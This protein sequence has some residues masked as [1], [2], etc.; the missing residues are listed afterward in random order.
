[1]DNHEERQYLDL[2]N[3]VISDG[4]HKGDRTGT[5]TLSSFGA[6]MRF[7][8]RD[9]RF[10]LLTTKR[11]FWRGVAEELLWIISGSTDSKKLADKGVHIWD[12]NGSREFLDEMGFKDRRE[13]DL[14]QIYGFQLRHFGATYKDCDTD[15]TGQGVDQLAQVID[16]IKN[17]P[18]DRRI[19]MSAWNPLALHDMALPPCFVAGTKVLTDKG[20]VAIEE[21]PDDA[22]L[23][24]HLGNWKPIN[25]KHVTTKM[26]SLIDINVQCHPQTLSATGE[27]PFYARLAD[28]PAEWI[29][30][31]DLTDKHFVA[32]PVNSRSIMPPTFK[33]AH[34]QMSPPIY[35]YKTL[36]T[37]DEFW[38]MGYFLGDGRVILNNEGRTKYGV[39]FVVCHRDEEEVARRLKA[40]MPTIYRQANSGQWELRDK[41][42]WNILRE[43]GHKAGGKR[44][45]EWVQD[46]PI[47]MV[48]AFVDGY[49]RADGCEMLMTTIS[50]DVAFGVQ[51]LFFKLGRWCTVL[52]QESAQVATYTMRCSNALVVAEHVLKRFP[53]F[54]ADGFAW[55]P[56]TKLSVQEESVRTV[57][58]FDVAEDHTYIVENVAVHNC[59]A[60]CQFYV[61]N[62]ELSCQMYQRSCDL[63]LGVPFNIAS[64]SLLTVMIAHICGLKPGEFVH[65]L[66]DA[67]VYLNHVD[68]LKLQLERVPRD[69]PKLHIKR[70][71]ADIDS[72]TIDDFELTDYKPYGPIKMDMAV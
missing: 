11:V 10:P 28:G 30:A 18:N 66:G 25:V 36:A 9:G 42:W 41:M 64:Y 35:S 14:G 52:R 31:A 62:G 17:N 68:P 3:K 51:R 59:H 15:Y 55:S 21:V 23:M 63:G 53:R 26:T 16:K 39:Y 46:S 56:I 57:Y 13:G 71:V 48:K 5:G 29:A 60:M 22:M 20:Y 2:V 40:V 58:N 43:F 24:T 69:F 19:I 38:V 61:A 50:A 44:I 65:S 45:P 12:G 47:E 8:L 7:S 27:H 72:F 1:M 67:H 4:V 70:A 6:Q 49:V 32:M 37:E 54:F 34:T 33:A